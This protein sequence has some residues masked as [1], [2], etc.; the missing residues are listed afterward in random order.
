MLGY[1]YQIINKVDGRR[2]IGQTINL[3]KRKQTHFSKLRKNEHPNYLLQNA[4]NQWGEENFQFVYEEFEIED[5]DT[6]NKKEISTIKKYNSYLDGYNRTAGGQ[7]GIIKRKLTYE[8]FCFIYYGCQWAGMT[9]K[10]AKYLEIDSSTVSSI[11]REKSHKD[12]LLQSKNL[13]KE[14]IAKIQ[15]NFK[16]IFNI[17]KEKLPDKNRCTSHLTE[18][19]YFYCLCI[20]STYGRGIEAALGKYFNKHKSF[21]SNGL[22]GKNT[23]KVK[24][25]QER[26]K[27]LTFNE[28]EQIG[29]KKFEEWEI[30]KYSKIKIKKEFNSKW[31]N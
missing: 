28:V 3:E 11:L 16:E 13:S 21:L 7:G 9:E 14:D 19:E 17:S 29:I 23:G 31:R 5:E 22:K 26:L 25:A 15:Q 18:D 30:D 2:Y 27:S 12:Y 6:L 20:A 24:R 1:I 8:D 10:I 4:W